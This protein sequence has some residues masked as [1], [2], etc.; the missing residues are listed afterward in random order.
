MQVSSLSGFLKGGA[1]SWHIIDKSLF[2]W[3][4]SMNLTFQ[5]YRHPLAKQAQTHDPNVREN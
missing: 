5:R 3:N 1:W 2:K 4:K